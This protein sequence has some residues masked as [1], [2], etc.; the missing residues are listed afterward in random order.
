[1]MALRS[2]SSDYYHVQSQQNLGFGKVKIP[3]KSL[4]LAPYSKYKI[5]V[6]NEDMLTQAYL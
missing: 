4:I 3:S 1:M 2:L 5:L 6:S